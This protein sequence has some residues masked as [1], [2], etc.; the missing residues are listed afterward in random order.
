[1]TNSAVA[2]VYAIVATHLIGLATGVARENVLGEQEIGRH[3]FVAPGERPIPSIIRPDD[4]L[5]IIEIGGPLVLIERNNN[6]PTLDDEL[7]FRTQY[8]DVVAIAELVSSHSVL[9]DNESWIETD[10]TLVARQI[11]KETQPSLLKPDGTI[12]FRISGGEMQIG[13]A[14]VRADNHYVFKRGERHLVFLRKVS[15]GRPASIG[16]LGVP[17]QIT[18]DDRLAPMTMSNGKPM[19]A[20]NAL[21]D[22]SLKTVIGEIIMRMRP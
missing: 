2:F 14:R 6:T 21:N 9:S 4:E 7:T 20:P 19:T 17:Y 12:T 11:V 1:M 5:V 15:D 16:L 13:K 22:M 3:I 10:V 18:K 8:A